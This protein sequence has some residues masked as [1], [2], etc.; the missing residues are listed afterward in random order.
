MSDRDIKDTMGQ[1]HNDIIESIKRHKL[2][3][4]QVH[5]TLELIKKKLI[6]LAEKIY[7]NEE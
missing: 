5:L 3:I 6:N 7:V 1:F 2:T 4:P